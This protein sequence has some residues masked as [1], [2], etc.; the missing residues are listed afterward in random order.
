M[1]LDDDDPMMTVMALESYNVTPSIDPMT[2]MMSAGDLDR[3]TL[4]MLDDD[5][6]VAGHLMTVMTPAGCRS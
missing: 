2:V 5:A 4:M 1:P 6:I 3:M